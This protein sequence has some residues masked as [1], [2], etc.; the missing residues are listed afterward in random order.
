MDKARTLSRQ[1]HILQSLAHML[2]IAPGQRITTALLAKEMGVSEAALYRHFPSKAKMFE[3]LIAFIE[4]ILFSR[5]TTIIAN[6]EKALARCGS[7]LRLLLS[8]CEKNPGLSR[9][10]TGDALAGEAQRLRVRISQLFERLEI[11]LKQVLREAEIKEGLR[12]SMTVSTTANLM[13][14]MVEGRIS[15]YVRGEFKHKP[16]EYW[17]DQWQTLA[18]VIFRT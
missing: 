15:K 11:Q 3:G 7:I 5:I 10:L 13:M 2:E 9:L 18:R 1:E 4:D 16:T 14:A 6:E 17:T 12:T 8:F